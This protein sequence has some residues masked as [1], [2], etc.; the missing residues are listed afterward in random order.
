MCCDGTL[1]HSVE[2]QSGDEPRKLSS[3][4]LK[5]RSKKGVAFFLQPCSANREVNGQC[6]CAIY[7]QRPIRCRLFD[8]LQLRGVV[9]GEISEAT[10]QEKILH[11]RSLVAQVNAQIAQIAETNPNRSLAHRVANAMTLPQGG[12]AATSAERDPLQDQL[13]STMQELESFLMKEF[14]VSA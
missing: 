1:F 12:L 6:S 9:A 3:L 8:C 2:L 5:L 14:R 11:A 4:G 7:E 13:D 10:A